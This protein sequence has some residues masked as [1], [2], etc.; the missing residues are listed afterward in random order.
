M[1]SRDSARDQ[2]AEVAHIASRLFGG[3]FAHMYKLN[4]TELEWILDA[5][6]PSSSFSTLKK[7]ELK[8]FGEYRTQRLVLQAFD[9]LTEGK[10]PDIGN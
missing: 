1:A 2:N 8:E 9:L 3:I 4:R 6:P 10:F 7:R 5:K